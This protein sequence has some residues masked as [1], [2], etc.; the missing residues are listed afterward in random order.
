MLAAFRTRLD[1]KRTRLGGAFHM[2][3][4]VGSAYSERDSGCVGAEVQQ[5]LPRNGCA[6]GATRLE[7]GRLIAEFV[8]RSRASLVPCGIEPL[9]RHASAMSIAIVRRS[10]QL[11][12]WA[13]FNSLQENVRIH[14]RA[15][16]ISTLEKG[17]INEG[18]ACTHPRRVATLLSVGGQQT[19]ARRAAMDAL[20]AIDRGVRT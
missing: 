1:K 18:K 7:R 17:G 9:Q 8:L 2:P 3:I 14:Q 10:T 12:Y 11:S 4:E 20:T 6:H 16:Q 19:S 13:R 15:G 5:G